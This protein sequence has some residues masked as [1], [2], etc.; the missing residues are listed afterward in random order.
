MMPTP[1]ISLIVPMYNEQDSI[2]AFFNRV[3][4][5]L[6]DIT[7]AYEV[8]CV[9]DG[10]HDNTNALL[11]DW[12]KK[13]SRIK[14]LNLSR[15]FGKD[16][17][18]SAGID[19]A[20][21]QAVIPIDADLQHPP[22]IIPE[23]IS[24]WRQG[25]DV[26]YAKR[27]AR[28]TENWFKR[29][30]AGWF[31]KLFNRVSKIKLPENTG[32]FRLM[33]Q[34]VVAVI[35]LLPERV[36]FMKGLFAWVGFTSCPVFYERTHRIAGNSKWNYWQL[37]NFALDGITAFT[38]LPLRIW[39]YIGLGVA[40]SSFLYAFFIVSKTLIFG[41]DVPGYASLIVVILFL[42]GINLIGIGIIGEYIGRT[43]E[44]SKSR[45]LYIIQDA[46]GLNEPEEQAVSIQDPTN[47]RH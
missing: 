40:T 24:K 38:S 14:S 32:D 22:E 46:I 44:E 21:G 16:V 9:N 12:H 8:I 19:H 25:Y 2:P 6:E 34:R 36:R 29:K 45:P 17:A 11:S 30:S 33:D 27:I 39:S 43:Y 5:I 15:N 31:Y 7:K 20:T 23:M 3:L 1:L 41:I 35:K 26:V 4:P 13:N 37:W 28:D 47:K 18:L 10:S 42:G